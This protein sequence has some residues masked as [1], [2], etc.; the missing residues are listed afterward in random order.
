MLSEKEKKLVQDPY[1]QVLRLI[2]DYDEDYVELKSKCTMHCWAYVEKEI[3]PDI[4]V[5][6]VINPLKRRKSVKTAMA[7]RSVI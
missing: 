7:I 5:R 4:T 2:E 1:F 3:S 6:S